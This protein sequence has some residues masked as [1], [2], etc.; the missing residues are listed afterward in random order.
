M[1]WLVWGVFVR[2]VVLWHC[3]GREFGDAYLRFTATTTP[4]E[5]ST[6]NWLVAIFSFGEGWHNNHHADQ[7]SAA[8]GQR[9]FEVDITYG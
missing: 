2:T 1:S 3:T 6:N 8:H 7:R 4:D 5:E 9:W